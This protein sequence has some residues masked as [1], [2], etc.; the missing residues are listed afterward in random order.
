MTKPKENT[1]DWKLSENSETS[2]RSTNNGR[3]TKRKVYFSFSNWHLTNFEIDREIQ[4]TK[5][6]TNYILSSRPSG[7]SVGST[8]IRA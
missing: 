1:T 5:G 4:V 7:K 8:Q 6:I 2:Q 3:L